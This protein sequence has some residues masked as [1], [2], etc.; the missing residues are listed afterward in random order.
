MNMVV[1][2]KEFKG[3]NIR[4]DEHQKAKATRRLLPAALYV[5]LSMYFWLL[6]CQ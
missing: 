6:R 3:S 5:I 4:C 2:K 1:L